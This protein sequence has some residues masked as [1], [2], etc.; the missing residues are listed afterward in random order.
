MAKVAVWGR[1]LGGF[2]FGFSFFV[3]FFR[4]AFGVFGVFFSV[5]WAERL[6]VEHVGRSVR[7]RNGGSVEQVNRRDWR[8][9]SR[10]WK[11]EL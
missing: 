3:T 2:G 5:V 6:L 1:G 4:L 9:E 11:V 8:G 10:E 7:G